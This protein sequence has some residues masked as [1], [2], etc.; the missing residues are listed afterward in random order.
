MKEDTR[1]S[2]PWSVGETYMNL[3]VKKK[4]TGSD[5]VAMDID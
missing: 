4:I 3:P 5:V 2:G 1:V